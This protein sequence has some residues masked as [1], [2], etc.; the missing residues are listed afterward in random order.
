MSYTITERNVL[1]LA[2]NSPFLARVYAT[3]QTPV[4]DA[5]SKSHDADCVVADASILCDGVHPGRRLLSSPHCLR[6]T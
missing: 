6:L 4:R 5:V 3:F 2:E 1:T